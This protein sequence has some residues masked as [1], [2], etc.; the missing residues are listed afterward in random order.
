MSIL[1]NV[2]R[3]FQ[4]N[5]EMSC[6]DQYF[7]SNWVFSFTLEE[8]KMELRL[9]L[10]MSPGREA[11]CW[12]LLSHSVVPS[13]CANAWTVA[14]QAPRPWDFPSKNT[15]VGCHFLLQGIS[16]TQGL[17]PCLRVCSIAGRFFTAETLGEAF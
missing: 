7:F 3:N 12:L 11:A 6:S 13:S 14:L 10:E 8:T 2:K 15:G 1:Y 9:P 5:F 16:L 4:L 17:N